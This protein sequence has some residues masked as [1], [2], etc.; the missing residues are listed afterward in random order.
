MPLISDKCL[1]FLIITLTPLLRVL[2]IINLYDNEL[3][4]FELNITLKRPAHCPIPSHK[5]SFLGSEC[6]FR[7]FPGLLQTMKIRLKF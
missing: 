4:I 7:L 2:T 1:S 6:R 5:F 3:L